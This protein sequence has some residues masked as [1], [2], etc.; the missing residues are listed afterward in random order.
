FVPHDNPARWRQI[1]PST[2]GTA[3]LGG[4]AHRHWKSR[5]HRQRFGSLDPLRQLRSRRPLIQG[6]N[7]KR[8]HLTKHMIFDPTFDRLTT[9]RGLVLDVAPS[10]PAWT[11]AGVF[12]NLA[13]F[14]IIVNHIPSLGSIAALL[15]LA[16]GI[17]KKDEAIKQFAYQVLVLV[18]MAVLPTY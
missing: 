17:Y 9:P 4:Q 3:Q 10:R 8:T 6:D 14:H 2:R 7:K 12:M 16:A 1:G 11:A 13:H 5:P 18:A 15:L